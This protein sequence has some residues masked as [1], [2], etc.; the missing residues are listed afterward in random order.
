MLVPPISQHD[1]RFILTP[2]PR[3]EQNR[4]M[5]QPPVPPEPAMPA[6]PPARDGRDELSDLIKNIRPRD[7]H[8]LLEAM[9]ALGPLSKLC[10]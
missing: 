1:P 8:A 2:R 5:D 4:N 3:R 9:C 6:S 10:R 7:T